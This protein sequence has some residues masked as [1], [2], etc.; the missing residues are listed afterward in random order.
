M[1]LQVAKSSLRKQLKAKILSID[2]GK[3]RERSHQIYKKL[4][5]HPKYKHAQSI[6]L[7]V[8]M[9]TQEVTT[10]DILKQCFLDNKQVYLPS[11]NLEENR[12]TMRLLRIK[13]YEQAEQLKP[14]GKF[15]IREPEEGDDIM[16]IGE[17]DLLIMPGLGF[18]KE[19]KRLGRGAG[20]YDTFLKSY[21]EKH[22]VSPFLIG[23]CLK[24][25]IVD[26]LP[27]EQH[28]VGLDDV[29]FA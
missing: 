11:C 29:I 8:H 17:L 2:N 15:M 7:Y 3:L 22:G 24:E 20:I 10:L 27:T 5:N 28:D 25:Q 6:G 16:D 1:S 21:K 26:D 18:T 14:R 9:A 4:L 12:I 13:S 23:I 19:G